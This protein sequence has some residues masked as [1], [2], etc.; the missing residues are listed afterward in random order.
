MDEGSGSMPPGTPRRRLGNFRTPEPASRVREVLAEAGIPP[1][2]SPTRGGRRVGA[3]AGPAAHL[4]GVGGTGCGCRAIGP[5]RR[6][7]CWRPPAAATSEATRGGR[8]LAVGTTVLAWLAFVVGAL[9]VVTTV[10][11]AIMTLVVPRAI[12]VRITRW[13]CSRACGCCSGCAEGGPDLRGARPGHGPGGPISLFVLAAT[14]L[15]LTG[16]GYTLLFWSLGERPLRR[17]VVLSGS[18]IYTLGFE[19][20]PNLPTTL[21]AFSEAGFGLAAGHGDQLPA[22]DVPVV[23]AAEAAVATLDVR[24]DTLPT[25]TAMLIR[26]SIIG[27][28]SGSRSC[29]GT[30]SVVRGRHRDPHLPAGAGVLPLTLLAAVVGHGG[31]GGAGRGVAAGVDGGPPGAAPTPVSHP[32]RLRRLGGGSPTSSASATTPTR[33]GPGRR[34]RSTGREFDQVCREMASAGVPS[35]PTLSRRGGTSPAGGSPTTGCCWPWPR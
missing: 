6:P 28:W 33:T 7:G 8:R 17:A 32:R 31:G 30:G 25:A 9:I 3:A 35:R 24:A 21:L 12:P 23:P 1:A 34:S 29:G 13:V 10:L 18:S 11:S 20:P 22:L 19:V 14:W 26:V 27:G 2:A 16:T 5:G 15:L 4:A